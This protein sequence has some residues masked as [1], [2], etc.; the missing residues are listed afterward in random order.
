[1]DSSRCRESRGRRRQRPRRRA[2]V[3]GSIGS[4]SCVARSVEPRGSA[5]PPNTR[6]RPDRSRTGN[7]GNSEMRRHARYRIVDKTQTWI[8]HPLARGTREVSVPR[9]APSSSISTMNACPS[10]Q[11]PLFRCQHASSDRH[12]LVTRSLIGH[13]A[14]NWSGI[15]SV[16]DS[17]GD[18]NA[19]SRVPAGR[20]P[21]PRPHRRP[22]C[23]E[24]A[25]GGRHRDGR[26]G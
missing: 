6:P 20:R 18:P 4:S 9:V 25:I 24:P 2:T 13:H 8:P 15:V 5:W 26:R 21:A 17:T 12:R 22:Q 11:P 7:G 3:A 10:N 1:V 14:R 19:S 16:P 23:L